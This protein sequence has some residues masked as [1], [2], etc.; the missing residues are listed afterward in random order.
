[1]WFK[2]MGLGSSG[3]VLNNLIPRMT[4]D[5]TPEGET[6]ASYTYS[7]RYAYYGFTTDGRGDKH[8]ASEFWYKESGVSDA[9]I[10]YE[11]E[12]KKT[13]YEIAYGSADESSAFNV[14]VQVSDDGI[15]WED[16]DTLRPSSYEYEW[17]T[18]SVPKS[19]KFL[20]LL[21]LSS[22]FYTLT[23]IQAKG[24]EYQGGNLIT[25]KNYAKFNGNGL[26]LPFTINSD[27]KVTVEF[28]QQTYDDT[29]NIIGQTGNYIDQSQLTIYSHKYYTAV[30][31]GE[32]NFGTW[33]AG[34][35]IF[36]TNNGNNHNEFDGVEVT[37]YTPVTVN[38]YY[39]IGKR[40][41]AH[42]LSS[43]IKHYKIESISTGNVICD[44]RPCLF[45][46]TVACLYD[47]V[48]KR[49]YYVEGLTVMDTI[50][51]T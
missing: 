41:G 7:R 37:N 33:S 50:P 2:C 3:P 46:D 21:C 8:Y 9:W 29:E 31:N 19:G 23:G 39:T 35:H 17:F 16:G 20:R 42:Y 40:Y 44:I 38:Y 32:T 18:L 51:T 25:I 26:E 11:F 22:S 48:N 13:I 4:S 30:G 49:F 27:Y 28:N 12:T 34:E 47:S 6:S 36:V 14:K 15:T 45:D 1:M 10:Q 5:T 43:Y 24:T